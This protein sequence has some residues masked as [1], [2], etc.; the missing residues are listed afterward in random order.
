MN[1]WEY[2]EMATEWR[3]NNFV[4]DMSEEKSQVQVQVHIINYSQYASIITRSYKDLISNEKVVEEFDDSDE[5]HQY[6]YND[7]NRLR[8]MSIIKYAKR[9]ILCKTLL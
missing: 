6:N 4:Q 1:R 7:Q 9:C 2:I 3:I 8:H 5:S